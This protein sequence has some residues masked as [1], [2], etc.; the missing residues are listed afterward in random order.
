MVG[1]CRV[2]E[3]RTGTGTGSG[4]LIC[5]YQIPLDKRHEDCEVIP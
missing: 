1:K 2:L 4:V 3:G 5:G